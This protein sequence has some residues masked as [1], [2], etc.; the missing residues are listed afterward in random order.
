VGLMDARN[1]RY[2]RLAASQRAVAIRSVVALPGAA[3]RPAGTA[4]ATS[5]EM[6]S[7]ASGEVTRPTVLVVEDDDDSRE[8]LADVLRDEGY[9]V[10]AACDG[11][12][13]LDYL[14]GASLPAAMVL[15]MRMPRM[16]GA[17]VLRLVRGR[18]RLAGLPICVLSGNVEE[19]DAADLVIEKP[20]LVTRLVEVQRW[21]E[22][23]VAGSKEAVEARAHG[24]SSARVI[25]EQRGQSSDSPAIGAPSRRR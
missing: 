4:V 6:P 18:P 11:V 12:E 10:Q 19:A 24:A 8:S 5:S 16:G 9:D 2:R 3:S 25:G 21:L 15:D 13:A 1:R 7:S 23:C 17:E 20:L 22:E 14:N